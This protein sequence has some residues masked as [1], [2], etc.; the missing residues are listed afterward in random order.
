MRTQGNHHLTTAG[1]LGIVRGLA[2]A[3]HA[4]GSQVG[5][6]RYWIR[7]PEPAPARLRAW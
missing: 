7:P 4:L 1:G 6:S 5:P 2:E 3:F